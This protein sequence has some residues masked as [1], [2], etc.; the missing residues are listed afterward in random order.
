MVSKPQWITP[1][2]SLGTIPEGIFYQIPLKADAELAPGQE[3]YYIMISGSLPP[4]VQC[5]KTGLIEGI[6]KAVGS[7]QGV[8]LPVGQDVTSKFTVRIYIE[9][10]EVV[11][12][13]ADRTFTITV[14]GED[15][16]NFVTPAGNIG[17]YYDGTEVS[18]QIEFTDVDPND[19]VF[20]QVIDGELPPGLVLLPNGTIEGYIIP[21]QPINAPAGFDLTPEYTFPY[22]FLVRSQNRNYQF[23]VEITDG[24]QSNIRTFSIFVYSRDSMSADATDITS[25]NTFITADE[26]PF[27]APLLLNRPGSIG[28]VRH[29]NFYSYKFNAVDLDG[30]FIEYIPDIDQDGS[31]ITDSTLALPPGTTLDPNTG[32]LYGYIPNLGVSERTY[33]FGV[34][35]RKIAY[36]EYESGPY[37]FSLTIIGAVDTEV[38]W[39]SPSQ[40][41]NINNGAVSLFEVVAVNRGGRVLSYSLDSGS[42][43]SLPQG[44]KLLSNGLIIGRVSFNTFALDGGTT[45]FDK[46][47]TTRLTIDEET[48]FDLDHTFTINA[49]SVDGLVSVYK[50]FTITVVRAFNEP[51]ENLY[52]KA[53]PPQNDRDLV[54]SLLENYTIFKPEY[55]YRADDPN[56]GVA[57]NVVYWHC[58]GLTSSTLEQYAAS[59][60]ENHYWKNLTLGEIKV[61]EARD[62][63]GNVIYEA[64]YSLIIDDLVNNQGESVNKQVTLP[65]P[66]NEGDSTEISVVYPNSLDNMRQQVIDQIGK[67]SN[68]LPLWMTSKQNN[69]QQL[70]FTPAWVI[71]YVKPGYGQRVAY[72]IRQQFGD[73][74]NK[75]DFTV[76]RYELDRALS[77]HWDPLA[78]STN[79]SWVPKAAMTTFDE[80]TT[81]FDGNSLKFIAPVDMYTSGDEYDKYLVFPKRN[82]LN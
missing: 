12:A 72:Y 69:G 62:S 25:D 14:T 30:A 2:G 44:L 45:T 53:M 74:L 13:V 11:L 43:S 67:I 39:L 73:Q 17:T 26:T 80:T 9:E 4:G 54:N 55:I 63:A 51:Y 19:T 3:L 47:V 15:F 56:F 77:I 33:R 61:A 31:S 5:R 38:T 7:F 34:S 1:A 29:D 27:R 50:T 41:G 24:K 59:L 68:V 64:I 48:T 58:F 20:C 76:D 46:K 21:Q 65:Y 23:T 71:C 49:T 40:L 6:P 37:Y 66:V 32:W 70:G 42:N 78:D 52:I 8:P 18:I 57:S 28:T 75:V 36:P 35:V 10:D 22:D 82:I 16:P 79:A 81:Y 60:Y